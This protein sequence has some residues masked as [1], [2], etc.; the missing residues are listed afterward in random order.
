[1]AER[2][3]VVA[4]HPVVAI[5]VDDED[6][7]LIDGTVLPAA[8]SADLYRTAVHAVASGVARPLGRPVR[9]MATDR[10]GAT[11]LVIHPD[12]SVSDIET[13]L[14][15]SITPSPNLRGSGGLAAQIADAAPE[16]YPA[17]VPKELTAQGWLAARDESREAS[18]VGNEPRAGRRTRGR[19]GLLLTIAVAVALGV[20]G[21]VLTVGDDEPGGA[22]AAESDDEDDLLAGTRAQPVVRRSAPLQLLQLQSASATGSVGSATLR[23]SVSRQGTLLLLLRPAG[24]ALSEQRVRVTNPG[25]RSVMI[26]DLAAGEWRWTVQAPGERA[27]TGAL[28]VTAPPAVV[29]VDAYEPPTTTYVPPVASSDDDTDDGPTGGGGGGDE[30]N[31]GPVDPDLP[32]GPNGPV[33]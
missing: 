30:G 21:V 19:E 28:R 15:N 17:G 7:I 22:R 4:S 25:V 23:F 12:G 6:R 11:R 10:Y 20:G 5:D 33:G 16:E 2:G 18:K 24:G 3:D 29:Q 32:T 14:P 27:L 8:E 26:R 1:M 9:A 13:V 31:G